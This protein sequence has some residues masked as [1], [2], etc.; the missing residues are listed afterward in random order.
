M[1]LVPMALAVLVIA[2]LTVAIF[3]L[4]RKG[5]NI[6]PEYE[7]LVIFRLGKCIGAQGPGLVFVVPLLERAVPV[8]T[9]ERFHEVSHE[10]CITKD[11]AKID[12]D[13][14]FYWKVVNPVWSQTRVQK[15]EA[16]LEGLATGLLRAVVGLFPLDDALAQR[17]RI[18]EELK[19]KLEEVSEHWGVTVTTVE[20]REIVPPKDIQDA[21]HR[22]LAAERDRRAV[23]LEAQGQRENAILRAEGGA[24]ALER[25]YRAAKEIDPKTLQLKYFDALIELGKSNS[26]KFIFPLEFTQLI[27]PFVPAVPG[28]LEGGD[29]GNSAHTIT[30]EEIA[31]L[32]KTFVGNTIK[33]PDSG[34]NIDEREFEVPT[35]PSDIEARVIPPPDEQAA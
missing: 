7:R 18:N 20:I 9:R 34:S 14:L 31:E 1:D 27:K 24:L 33:N 3:L 22:Q 16:S 25:L 21:M 23:I 13:F 12:V 10:A 15:L 19:D 5:M 17:E 4:I 29:A 32:L 26:T 30:V 8:D 11:N 6:V 28:T 2:V 35:S